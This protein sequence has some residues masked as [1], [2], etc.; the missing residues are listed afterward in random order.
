MYSATVI[1]LF[2]FIVWDRV[3][4]EQ[5]SSNVVADKWED[6]LLDRSSSRSPE[7]HRA[8][9]DGTTLGK[10][11][12]ACAMG[13]LSAGTASA[14]VPCL[15]KIQFTPKYSPQPALRFDASTPDGTR[16]SPMLAHKKGAGSTKNGR[17]SNPKMLGVKVLGGQMTTAGSIL[18]RQRGS[19]TAPGRNVRLARDHTL[20]ALIDGKVVFERRKG[21][22]MV[23]VLPVEE[24]AAVGR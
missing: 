7:L 1:I 13:A 10:T 18:V 20:H 12:R 9:L 24:P 15:P 11:G 5:A 19:A 3:G 23:S 4:A 17:D 8:D 16:G 22:K 21:K 14:A 6:H 2:G